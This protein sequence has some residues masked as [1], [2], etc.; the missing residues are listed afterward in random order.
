[1]GGVKMLGD[2]Q[3]FSGLS[4]EEL[5]TLKN[6]CVTKKYRKNTV[7]L[8]K[9]DE[10]KSLYIIVSGRIKVYVSGENGK[11]VVLN[12]QGPGEHFGELALLGESPR[13]ASVVTLEDSSFLVISKPAFLDFLSNH[14]NIAFNLIK[15]LVL[16]VMTLTEDVSSL[17]LL[18]VYGRIAKMLMDT[19]EEQDEILVT[20]PLTQ[21]DIANRV[22]A[23]REMVSRILKDLKEGGYITNQGKRIVINK[24]LPAHW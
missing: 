3:L 17:A 20:E 6:H 19:A 13:T 9:G 14:P 21:Q 12:A 1:M 11:E 7:I 23:S 2:I 8:E 5:H 24:H 16:R 15:A 22:G 18:D 4:E 10:T